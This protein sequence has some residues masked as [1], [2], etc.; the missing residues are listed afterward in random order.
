MAP[1]ES[2][3]RGSPSRPALLATSFHS[4]CSSFLMPLSTLVA[5]LPWGPLSF[6]TTHIS[7]SLLAD[8]S[9]CELGLFPAPWA[10]SLLP[11]QTQTQGQVNS[12]IPGNIS[13][14]FSFKEA[15]V[16][17]GNTLSVFSQNEPKGDNINPKV[18]EWHR[19]N[20]GRKYTQMLTVVISGRYGKS[21]CFHGL[22]I[23][24]SF[25]LH[26]QNAFSS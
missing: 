15:D 10:R 23:F 7:F 24:S 20:A 11:G 5:P 16:A 19:K 6:L 13:T 3:D 22:E 4:R 9:G 26:T 2:V 17:P 25:L 18:R 21:F 8:P 12:S 14:T 1:Q